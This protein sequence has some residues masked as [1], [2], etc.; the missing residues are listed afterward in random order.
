MNK[1]INENIIKIV[2]ST[3]LF[4]GHIAKTLSRNCIKN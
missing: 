3:D 2:I 1:Q 4:V